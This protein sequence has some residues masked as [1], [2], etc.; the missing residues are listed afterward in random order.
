[1]IPPHLF[2][3]MYLS[4]CFK[5]NTISVGWNLNDST[6][7]LVGYLTRVT[8][9]LKM[10]SMLDSSDSTQRRRCRRNS[11]KRSGQWVEL[12]QWS[13]YSSF[14]P[15]SIINVHSQRSS[16]VVTTGGSVLFNDALNT[17]YLRL[18]GRK[19]MFYFTTHSTHFIY[20]YMEGRKEMFY[21]TTHSTH[22]IYGYM[23]GRKEMFYLTTHSTYF[24]YGYMEGRKEMFY[25]T[26]HSTHFIYGYMEGRKEMFYLTTHSTHFIYGY[27]EGR[28]CFISRRTQHILFT[29][30]WKEGRKCFI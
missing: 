12:R 5:N 27:M 21:I 9:R 29:V 7:S 13:M 18:Y 16:P 8:S 6:T 30:T 2:Y 26:T 19:E 1:M 23:E 25:L 22:F 14:Q 17:F 11:V 3:Q 20:G 24:I 4:I 28:K 10:S 15:R